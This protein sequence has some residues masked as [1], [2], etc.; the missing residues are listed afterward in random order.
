M[1]YLSVYAK[2]CLRH[3]EHDCSGCPF[4]YEVT[5]EDSCLRYI[6]DNKEAAMAS[7]VEY[8]SKHR[9]DK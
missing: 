9:K 2:I 8:V 3:S 7:M 4:A 5:G 6:L 1:K